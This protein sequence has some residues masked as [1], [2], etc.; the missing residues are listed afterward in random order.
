MHSR[1]RV[2]FFVKTAESLLIV[3]FLLFIIDL[4]KASEEESQ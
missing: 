3:L 2:K 4:F 1:V